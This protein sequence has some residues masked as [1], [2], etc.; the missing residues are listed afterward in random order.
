[1]LMTSLSQKRC[2]IKREPWVRGL[3]RSNT[4]AEL[5]LRTL[6]ATAE[7]ARQLFLTVLKY[8]FVSHGRSAA[9][10]TRRPVA[11]H[12][13][14]APSQSRQQRFRKVGL[15]T[16]FYVPRPCSGFERSS[17]AQSDCCMTIAPHNG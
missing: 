8:A 12:V 15:R 9:G 5:N 4:R 14:S 1:M 3:P 17:I 16:T 11:M 10:I 7:A 6:L 2:T 13:G